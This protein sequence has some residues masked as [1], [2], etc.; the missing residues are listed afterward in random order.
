MSIK[1]Y[2][3]VTRNKDWSETNRNFL[4]KSNAV[5]YARSKENY[6]RTFEWKTEEPRLAED[7]IQWKRGW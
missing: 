2:T 6:V 5:I 1:V 4:L 3:V 7:Y